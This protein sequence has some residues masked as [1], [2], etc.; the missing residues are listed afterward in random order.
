S[1][2]AREYRALVRRRSSII[3]EVTRTK[4][5]IKSLL[6]FH[7]ISIPRDYRR[8]N[9]S[10]RFIRWLETVKLTSE[11]GNESLESL[12]RQ[13]AY[14]RDEEAAMS[15]KIRALARTDPYKEPAKYLTSIPGIGVISAMIWLTELVD[16]HRFQRFDH[17]TSYVGL[18]P[19]ERSSGER[20]GTAGLDRR[21]NRRLRTLL[22]ENSWAAMRKDPGLM[23]AYY[24]LTHRMHGNKAIIRI[25]RKL[26]RRIRYVLIHETTYEMGLA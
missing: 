24:E 22:I 26:L 5:R 23:S 19:W 18:V 16:I 3:K 12:L 6:Q 7:G 9:W 14:Y 2:R 11:S 20:S 15:R 8:R 1:V 21:G 13:L 25:A 4:N 17:L 10:G